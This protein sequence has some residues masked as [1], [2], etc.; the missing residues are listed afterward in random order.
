[1]EKN[2]RFFPENQNLKEEIEVFEKNIGIS[3]LLTPQEWDSNIR[4]LLFFY[5][6]KM[7]FIG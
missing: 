5:K 6:G 2:S 3:F 1:M 7:V 4:D